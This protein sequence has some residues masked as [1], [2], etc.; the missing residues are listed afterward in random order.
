MMNKSCLRLV[1]SLFIFWNSSYST[2]AFAGGWVDKRPAKMVQLDPGPGKRNPLFYVGEEIK[3][4]L[5]GEGAERYEVR[6]FWGA[7]V[8][9]GKSAGAITIKA[10]PPGWYKIYLFASP[11]KE[12]VKYTKD[13]LLELEL[14]GKSP[15]PKLLEA[16]DK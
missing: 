6:D 5:K 14:A 15:D 9:K 11:I 8:D 2:D 3:F 16:L 10:Q 1:L 4:A 7:I 12:P 13:E